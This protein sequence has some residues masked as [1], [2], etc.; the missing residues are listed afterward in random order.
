MEKLYKKFFVCLFTKSSTK[1]N[2]KKNGKALI[3][4]D[5]LSD[6]THERFPSPIHFR[7]ALTYWDLNSPIKNKKNFSP[8]YCSGF[9]W[10]YLCLC[11]ASSI[12]L[13]KPTQMCWMWWE[14]KEVRERTTTRKEESDKSC[15]YLR[16]PSL[17][18]L[19]V[20]LSQPPWKIFVLDHKK[21]DIF[22]QTWESS[23]C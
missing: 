9:S 8:E 16:T 15:S 11:A 2:K 1:K 19:V 3:P 7:P 20:P 22:T 14:R 23:V 21:S 12:W 18:R 17:P 6:V 10:I 4:K 5:V 13:E